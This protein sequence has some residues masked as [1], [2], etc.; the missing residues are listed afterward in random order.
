MVER[1]RRKGSSS[2][3]SSSR[4]SYRLKARDFTSSSTR[5]RCKCTSVSSAT[6]QEW[7]YLSFKGRSAFK[8]TYCRRAAGSGASRPRANPALGVKE[9][10]T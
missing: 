3:S 8:L 9:R 10:G 5:H 4:Q 7:A 6:R 2:M 1:K